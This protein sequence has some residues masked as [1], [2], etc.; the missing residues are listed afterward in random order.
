M[1]SVC[2]DRSTIT[3]KTIRGG[4]LKVS[5]VCGT[6]HCR[7][8]DSSPSV[9]GTPLINLVVAGAMFFSGVCMRKFL[10][11]LSFVKIP[12]I[13]YR[14]YMRLQSSYVLPAVDNVW[15]RTQARLFEIRRG[16]ALR[17]GGDARCCSP[18][19]T[20]KYGSYTLMDL[21][22][23]HVLDVQLVQVPK[24][25][26][27]FAIYFYLLKRVYSCLSTSDSIFLY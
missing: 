5:T 16:T 9:S 17:L 26:C 21:E 3:K 13:S 24:L 11:C 25:A 22:T 8:W 4:Q 20:A 27:L 19:H 2:G 18:G 15:K 10:N 1:C 12:I 14:T 7:T 23:N 6:G